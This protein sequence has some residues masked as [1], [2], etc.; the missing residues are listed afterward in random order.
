MSERMPSHGPRRRART[1]LL[2]GASLALLLTPALPSAAAAVPATVTVTMARSGTPIAGAP[3]TFTPA[4]SGGWI[5]PD[6]ATCSWELVWGDLTS[7]VNH[8]YNETFGSIY[9]RGSA[10]DGFCDGWTVTLPYSAAARWRWNFGISDHADTFYDTT[11][12][13]PGPD[14]PLMAGSNGPGATGGIAG[15]T[16]PG[17]WLSMPKGSLIGDRVTA[18][19][20]P[21]G[22]YVQ[23]PGGTS[24][25]SAAGACGCQHL[26]NVTNHALTYTFTVTASGTWSVFYNDTGEANGGPVAGAG[27]D[28]QVRFARRVVLRGPAT[29]HRR[30]WFTLTTLT[31][32]FRGTV[33]YHCYVDRKLLSGTASKRRLQLIG[34]GQRVVTVSARDRYGHHSSSTIR[35]TVVP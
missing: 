29:V 27:I 19:A 1:T 22:G 5:V 34:L 11:A 10:A 7:L 8:A 16:L 18:T 6:D 12:F 15:S 25:T 23:P 28:P 24:W 4:Y 26:A 3:Y 21:F 35:V 32:G 33:T 13:S 20:H 31:Y 9:V 2:L 17:V 14:L 30:A